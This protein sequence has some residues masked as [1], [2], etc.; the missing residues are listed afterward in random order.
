MFGIAL[1]TSKRLAQ[2]L[3]VILLLGSILTP[4]VSAQ[5]S[6]SQL[7]EQELLYLREEENWREMSTPRSSPHLAC[8]YSAILHNPNNSI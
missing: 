6:L 1:Q 4:P 8:K 7:E 2:K 5:L 3:S